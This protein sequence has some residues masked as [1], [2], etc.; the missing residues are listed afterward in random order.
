M[1]LIHLYTV[2]PALVTASASPEGSFHGVNEAPIPTRIRG[3]NQLH[4]NV[5]LV[6]KTV[7]GFVDFV[8]TVGNTVMIFTPRVNGGE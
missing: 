6:T 8:T 3:N 2:T 7:A 5:K 1:F 4:G